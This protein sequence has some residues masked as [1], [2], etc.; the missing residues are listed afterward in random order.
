MC[1]VNS[2]ILI[3]RDKAKQ[4]FTKLNLNESD[5]GDLFMLLNQSKTSVPEYII[6][7]YIYSYK[8]DTYPVKLFI[9]YFKNSF[10][11]SVVLYY[12]KQDISK[13]TLDA[14]DIYIIEKKRD[15]YNKIIQHS[16]NIEEIP[17]EANQSVVFLP[18]PPEPCFSKMFRILFTTKPNPYHYDFFIA[19][20]PDKSKAT[21]LC[22]IK[23]KFGYSTRGNSYQSPF[24]S[25][26]VCLHS[27]SSSRENSKINKTM[28]KLTG[29]CFSSPSLDRLSL[30]S[31]R[32][33]P[34][35]A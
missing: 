24:T 34:N 16:I 10:N 12:L 15:Y 29:K 7:I 31:K 1:G 21:L 6:Y 11:F 2:N 18:S 3:T 20:P 5:Y 17:I 14:E 30:Y 27:H 28:S 25:S 4:F 8:C 35:P 22:Q 9:N 32:I 23:Q 13:I 19:V 33:Q 26:R